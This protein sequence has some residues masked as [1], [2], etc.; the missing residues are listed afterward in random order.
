M[1]PESPPIS[2]PYSAAIGAV[3]AA[4]AGGPSS[5]ESGSGDAASSGVT[6]SKIFNFGT[7]GNPNAGVL[8]GGAS[9]SNT[10]LLII[11]GA[12][13]LGLYFMHRQK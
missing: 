13:V 3:G 4:V 12:V 10:T 8:G 7:G 6:G 1:M 11:A 9:V 5:A 2:D